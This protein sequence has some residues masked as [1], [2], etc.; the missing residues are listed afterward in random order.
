[1]KSK[2]VSE[3]ELV[4]TGRVEESREERIRGGA[5]SIATIFPKLKAIRANLEG[6]T[7]PTYFDDAVN[8]LDARTPS[9][10]NI[11]RENICGR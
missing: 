11:P 4:V 1:M 3:L 8:L 10:P 9:A 5:T 2:Y 6:L 7:Q